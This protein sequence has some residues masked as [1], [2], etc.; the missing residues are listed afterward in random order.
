MKTK[1][2]LDGALECN[3]KVTEKF[4]KCKLNSLSTT[5]HEK[6]KEMEDETNSCRIC[7][8]EGDSDNPL[9]SI[10]KCS[11]SMKHI[12]QECLKGWI[13]SKKIAQ[14]KD[15]V[16][17]YL[18][19]AFEWELCKLSYDEVLQEK[20]GLLSY[21]NPYSQYIILEGININSS[22]S[23]YIV[24]LDTDKD[25]FIIGRGHDSDI[26]I[27]D[28]SVSRCHAK[29]FRE[30]DGLIL[31]DQNS[32]FGTLAW[33]KKPWC[34]SN[35]SSIH[36]QVGRT[37]LSVSLN[38]RRDWSLN[39]CLWL[40]QDNTPKLPAENLD[41]YIWNNNITDEMLPKEF[42][43]HLKK[44]VQQTS[45]PMVKKTPSSKW[46]PK[47]IVDDID[48]SSAS[49]QWESMPD[50]SVEMEKYDFFFRTRKSI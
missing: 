26:R 46:K 41:K 38:S 5:L 17:T 7:F 3:L 23:V 12:H 40:S 18:W 34:L 10:W 21:D 11:G 27:S 49:K 29:I 37:L 45:S 2:Q 31:K 22:K 13:N 6:G 36:L 8:M 4:E 14:A 48:S 15:N 35:Y 30:K 25:S 28:I 50:L 32:K 33:M 19:K 42:T 47:E 43:R 44:D 16:I 24:N 9:I 1:Q 39:G 20:Y